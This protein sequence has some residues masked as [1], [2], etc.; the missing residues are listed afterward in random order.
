MARKVF[1]K[2]ASPPPSVTSEDGRAVVQL[3]VNDDD[4]WHTI[5]LRVDGVIV[6]QA[7]R[8]DDFWKYKGPRC[9]HRLKY[10]ETLSGHG[11]SATVTHLHFLGS[12][13]RN[14]LPALK[15]ALAVEPD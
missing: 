13:Y 3:E 14:R 2:F 10:V 8:L 15:V 6:N 7:R 12:T 1:S 9:S 11:Y 5:T 4:L